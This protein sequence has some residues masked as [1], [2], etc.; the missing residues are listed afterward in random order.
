M[1]TTTYSICFVVDGVALGAIKK[2]IVDL[3]LLCQGILD[4]FVESDH[5]IPLS[6]LFEVCKRIL[7]ANNAEE[8]ELS[9]SDVTQLVQFVLD[10]P[11]IVRCE[12]FSRFLSMEDNSEAPVDHDQ[13]V[14]I[15]VSVSGAVDFLLQSVE[16]RQIYVARKNSY[17]EDHYLANRSTLVWK[18]CISGGYDVEF[19]VLWKT[20][21]ACSSY[22]IGDSNTA[23]NE[24]PLV[25]DV[26]QCDI[27][28][29][30]KEPIRVS[31]PLTSSL[32]FTQN[33]TCIEGSYTA[34]TE[35]YCRLVFN[36]SY[37]IINGK[38]IDIATAIVSQDAIEASVIAAEDALNARSRAKSSVSV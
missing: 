21:S 34:L 37:S 16:N 28:T 15:G 4:K 33:G 31:T 38:Y 1:T 10:S 25:L 23:C 7:S 6:S 11:D 5:S 26:E 14:K 27:S 9:I 12:P 17:F 29:A 19:G 30:I 22:E 8:E 35:G 24:V 13:Q 32:V 3:Q 2:S 36:N 20:R 18:F